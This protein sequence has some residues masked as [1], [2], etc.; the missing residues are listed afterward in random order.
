MKKELNGGMKKT[1]VIMLIII[2]GLFLVGCNQKQ[3]VPVYKVG[4]QVEF[5]SGTILLNSDSTKTNTTIRL[6]FTLDLQSSSSFDEL[7]AGYNIAV[8]RKGIHLRIS[9]YESPSTNLKNNYSVDIDGEKIEL[10]DLSTY[11]FSVGQVVIIFEFG[12]DYINSQTSNVSFTI[13]NKKIGS[14]VAFNF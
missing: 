2:S 5:E 12:T 7:F 14:E 6:C 3:E 9:N 10:T 11:E 4:E 13:L 1:S 8:D